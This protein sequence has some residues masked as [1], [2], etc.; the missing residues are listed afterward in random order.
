M[1]ENTE[2]KTV[3]T[4]FKK[5]I[6]NC[7]KTLTGLLEIYLNKLRCAQKILNSEVEK[8]NKMFKCS[9]LEE[10]EIYGFDITDLKNTFLIENSTFKL[11]YDENM[12]EYKVVFEFKNY[13]YGFCEDVSFVAFTK[14][15]SLNY[16]QI[17]KEVKNDIM[18]L[19][20]EHLKNVDSELYDT[21]REKRLKETKQRIQQYLFYSEVD[22][23]FEKNKNKQK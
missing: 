16:E 4:K 12:N 7:G 19:I 17:R 21:E 8:M 9:L 15:L 2:K 3:K 13:S 5:N 10:E 22:E 6:S 14:W 11:M 20:K 1:E 18:F 23:E